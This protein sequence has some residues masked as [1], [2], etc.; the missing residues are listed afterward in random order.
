MKAIEDNPS[1]VKKADIVVGIPSFNEASLIAYPT[2]QAAIGLKEYFND[3]NAVI[4]NCDNSSTDGTGNVFMNAETSGIPKIYLSTPKGVKG[5]GNNFKNLFRKVLELDAA[6]VIVVDADLKSITPRWIKNLGEPLFNDFGYVAPLYVRHKYDGTITNNIAYPL[7]RCLYGRRVRQPIGGDFGF[8]GKMANLY[9]KSSL[10]NEEVSQFGIDIWMTTI[11][12]NEGV[13]IC[14]AF[15]GRPKVHKPKDP[16][17]D[18][19]PMFK[20]V[21]STIFNLM[22]AYHD[23]W[24]STKWSKPTAIFGFG[25]GEV[26]MPPAV[27]VNK[28]KLYQRFREGFNTYWDVYRSIFSAENLQKIR[29]IASLSIDH[30]EMPVPVWAKVLFDFALSYYH[31]RVE[32]T[33]AIEVLIPLYYGMTLSFVNKTEGMSIQQAE[34]FLEDMCLVFEQTKPY[35]IDRWNQ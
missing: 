9:M 1:G 4:I 8:S 16:A 11:A 27:N 12:M 32:R 19:G 6:A 23:K 30:F 35:I 2:A 24:E 10:W 34:E 33:K 17:A 28:E 13:P 14:Q 7:T 25:L 21:I 15:M 20:Q 26:E 31:N 5:K 18:L 3:L 29:E 22:I